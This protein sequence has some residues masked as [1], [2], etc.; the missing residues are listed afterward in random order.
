MPTVTSKDGT[1]IGYDAV[2][3][4][5]ALIVVDGATGY[6]GAFGGGSELARLLAPHFTIYTYDRRGRGQSSDTQPFAVT[7]EVEDIEALIDAAGGEAYLYGMSSGGALALEA[8]LA[9]PG[10]VT[11]LAIYEVPYDD[12]DVGMQAWHN[13]RTTLEELTAAGQ[14]GDAVALFVQFVGVPADMIAGMRQS[15]IWPSLE[16]VAPTLRYDA[17][18]LGADRTVP[19]ER[20]ATLIIPTLIM[21]GGASEAILPFMRATAE[22]LTKAIPHA[23]HQILP[24][25]THDVDPKV[26]APVLTA[27]L[28]S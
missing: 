6:R 11:K 14:R 20:A 12:S 17:A 19:T 24:G 5:P 27:F 18:A 22:A 13:Y 25:Q 8:A 26:V 21:D 10:K 1:S 7:R 9:L 2:G 23:E 16:A 15:P 4:G 3:E 28:E